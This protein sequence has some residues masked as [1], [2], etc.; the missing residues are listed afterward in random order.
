VLTAD[1]K[2]RIH[3]LQKFEGSMCP[4]ENFYAYTVSKQ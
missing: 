1:S 2:F 3:L 4:Y